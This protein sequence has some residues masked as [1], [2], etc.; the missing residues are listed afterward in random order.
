MIVPKVGAAARRVAPYVPHRWMTPLH[1]AHQIR[2]RRFR[3]V[4]AEWSKLIGESERWSTDETHA[5]VSAQLRALLRHAYDHVPYY[6]RL[7]EEL[8]AH[9]DDIR[10]VPDLRLV[11]MLGKRELQDRT[12]ELLAT[13]IVSRDRTYSTTAGS[14]GIPVGFF[15]HRDT[16]AKDWAFMTSQWS[17]VGYVPGDPAAILRGVVVRGN[18]LFERA[19]LENALIMS[20][21]HLTEDRL[22]LYVSRLR[23]FRPKFIRAYPSSVTLLAQFM[24]ARNEEPVEGVK[25]VLCGSETLYDWQRRQVE[26]AFQCRVFS[27]YGQS[28]RV[29]LA[30]ECEHDARLHI[31]PQY[32]VVELVG[33][34]GEVIDSAGR[35]GEV[36]ATGLLN[37]A[38]PLIRYRTG[39]VAAFAAG[40]CEACGRPYRRLESVEGR[41]QEFIVSRSGRQISM[42]AINMHSPVFDNIYQFRFR[43]S[44]RG[45]ITLMIVP[46]Q[47]FD[48]GTDEPRIRAE[49]APKLGP[50][51]ELTL[52][53]VDDIPR[54]SRGKFRFLDQEL[55]SPFIHGA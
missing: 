48:R 15:Q 31:F 46:K 52:E 2:R 14:T 17:R 10:D 42:T 1:V 47:T 45:E 33:A 25:A 22:P 39:D 19:P 54:S 38:M 12:D 13:N 41:L 50:D 28:E 20:S 6:R 43:Q 44:V 9:P 16:A 51:F 18:R 32:G 5:Y 37:P 36:V 11:P 35:P 29:C 55:P 27:W 24:L 40:C 7:F 53:V 26:Q 30:G 49:L 23:E 21:Y 4:S 3:R 34:N 8:D